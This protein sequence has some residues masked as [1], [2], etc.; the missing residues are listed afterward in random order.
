MNSQVLV[1]FRSLARH[2]YTKNL[3]SPSAIIGPAPNVK[4]PDLPQG[5]AVTLPEHFATERTMD[6]H[7]YSSHAFELYC[8]HHTSAG[9]WQAFKLSSRSSSA[10]TSQRDQAG[11]ALY[12][13]PNLAFR[14]TFFR[15]S[16][17]LKQEM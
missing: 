14:L 12:P 11:Y 1:V 7:T 2:R 17:Q 6:L 8:G 13:Y 9:K 3:G 4:I 15:I 5:V 16:D 10:K